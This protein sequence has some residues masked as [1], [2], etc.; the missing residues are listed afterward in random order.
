MQ[1]ENTVDLAINCSFL[2]DCS[3]GLFWSWHAHVVLRARAE[4]ADPSLPPPLGREGV[5]QLSTKASQYLGQKNRGKARVTVVQNSVSLPGRS[6]LQWLLTQAMET[7]VTGCVKCTIQNKLLRCDTIR[8][9]L[10]ISRMQLCITLKWFHKFILNITWEGV[11][12]SVIASQN[13]EEGMNRE[14]FSTLHQPP[15]LG[16]TS[17]MVFVGQSI[18]PAWRIF[19]SAPNPCKENKTNFQLQHHALK[20]TCSV[21]PCIV[22]ARS[23]FATFVLRIRESNRTGS[24]AALYSPSYF[25]ASRHLLYSY[26]FSSG[27]TLRESQV[28][29]KGF[30]L[31]CPRRGAGGL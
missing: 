4:C 22:L 10:K 23:W 28:Y 26:L 14:I 9:H 25:T 11:K 5:V 20:Q 18:T 13:L 31:P 29:I 30:H 21:Q 19:L 1:Q 17:G 12:T 27:R 16:R 7:A 8:R 15:P 2:T 6:C 24:G 3:H